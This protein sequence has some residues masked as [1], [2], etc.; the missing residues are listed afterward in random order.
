MTTEIEAPVAAEA[1]EMMIAKLEKYKCY[2][3]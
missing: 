1:A 2:L 3:T